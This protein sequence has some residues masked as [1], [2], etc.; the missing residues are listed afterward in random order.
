MNYKEEKSKL[1]KKNM[2]FA[3]YILKYISDQGDE[4]KHENMLGMGIA[5]KKFPCCMRDSACI[6]NIVNN[7]KTIT[8][9]VKH[10]L[11]L[12]RVESWLV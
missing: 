10:F 4:C 8:I 12:L 1:N 3:F 6:R 9:Y 2:K 7:A 5:C 11:I